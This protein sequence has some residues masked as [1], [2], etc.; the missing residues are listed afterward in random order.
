MIFKELFKEENEGESE[1]LKNLLFLYMDSLKPENIR[2]GQYN[3][4]NEKIYQDIDGL[5]KDQLISDKLILLLSI[6]EG[7]FLK[8]EKAKL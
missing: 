5:N 8:T 4:L 2:Q 6:L 1:T 3:N 7:S